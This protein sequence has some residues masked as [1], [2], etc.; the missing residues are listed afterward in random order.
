MPRVI[1][2]DE[3]IKG[4]H[5]R[6]VSHFKTKEEWRARYKLMVTPIQKRFILRAYRKW[7]K[8]L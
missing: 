5:I 4:L 1:S 8:E 3:P 2:W 6:K 7:L